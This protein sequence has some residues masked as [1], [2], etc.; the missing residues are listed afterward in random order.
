METTATGTGR[1]I[2]PAMTIAEAVGLA[3][4][5][6][7]EERR[8]AHCW[9]YVASLHDITCRLLPAITESMRELHRKGEYRATC[10]INKHPMLES[11]TPKNETDHDNP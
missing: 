7:T 4:A 9:P 5:E 1:E 3:A 2:T 6:V 11:K 8:A 10:T